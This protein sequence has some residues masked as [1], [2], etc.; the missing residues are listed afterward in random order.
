MKKFII[1]RIKK[2]KSAGIAGALAHN[3]RTRVPD[4]VDKNRI[5]ENLV[6]DGVPFGRSGYSAATEKISAMLEQHRQVAGRRARSDA[7]LMVESFYSISPEYIKNMDKQDMM[8]YFRDCTDFAI[9]H[10]GGGN[11]EN[12][13]SAVVHLDEATPHLHVL[14]APVVDGVFNAKK[15]IGGSRNVLRQ[16]QTII[17]DEVGIK[18]GLDRGVYRELTGSKHIKN[19]DIQELRRNIKLHPRPER[20]D[21]VDTQ[22]FVYPDAPTKID[23]LTGRVPSIL[24]EQRRIYDSVFRELENANRVISSLAV[25]R[26]QLVKLLNRATI[27]TGVPLEF[28]RRQVRE[29]NKQVLRVAQERAE[30]ARATAQRKQVQLDAAMRRVPEL[31]QQETQAER[32]RLQ[33]ERE[34]IRLDRQLVEREMEQARQAL[35]RL[36]EGRCEVERERE[37]YA[38]LSA[39]IDAQVEERLAE[40][41]AELDASLA[42]AQINERRLREQQAALD[43][44]QDQFN[45]RWE[46]F[47]DERE[48]HGR[49][50]TKWGDQ[51]QAKF[52]D[53]RT[54]EKIERVPRD[55]WIDEPPAAPVV[56]RQPNPLPPRRSGGG[57]GPSPFKV[58]KPRPR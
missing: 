10:Y 3:L 14:T 12:L 55:A 52:I 24:I 20:V 11:S 28:L 38:Q 17:H 13:I 43:A 23:Y 37:R 4:Y 8:N 25:D 47:Q 9:R 6:L 58:R 53:I 22:N 29:E 5:G 31:V 45:A 30:Q 50:M 54:R 27:Q 26:A 49:Q 21:V 51:A 42:D 19:T 56:E 33:Q 7:V 40:R 41:R 2:L 18:Y 34:Q 35:K 32:E 36:E 48:E 39:G 57:R 1:H 15:L 44:A 46:Q 16:K